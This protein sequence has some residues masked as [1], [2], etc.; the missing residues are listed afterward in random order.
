MSLSCG[1]PIGH[2]ISGSYVSPPTIDTSY[3]NRTMQI[4]RVG[5]WAI[6]R[7]CHILFYWAAFPRTLN[8]FLQFITQTLPTKALRIREVGGPV[9]SKRKT[10]KPKQTNKQEK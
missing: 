5:T 4:P 3:V 7:H 6:Y 10:K 9:N 1:K 2:L 8:Y